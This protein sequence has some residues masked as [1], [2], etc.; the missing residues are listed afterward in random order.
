VAEIRLCPGTYDVNLT[1]ERS[2]TLVGAGNG[3]GPG[4]T[5]LN[6]GNNGRVIEATG[7]FTIGVRNV[8]ITGGNAT[9][10]GLSEEGRGGGIW[11]GTRLTMSD[12]TITGN[13]AQQGAVS[14]SSARRS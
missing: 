11:A 13:S 7:G 10:P 3:T 9:V 5:I 12:C 2:V 4:D 14:T 8:R 6:G 1:L